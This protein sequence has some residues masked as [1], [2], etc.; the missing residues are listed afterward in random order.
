MAEGEHKEEEQRISEKCKLYVV[1]FGFYFKDLIWVTG[2][3]NDFE[4]CVNEH[5]QAVAGMGATRRAE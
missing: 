1:G 5:P 2:E 3:T 4:L